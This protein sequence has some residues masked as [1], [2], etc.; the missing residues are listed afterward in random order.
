MDTN[1]KELIE[2]SC[3]SG[4]IT[5][6]KRNL[7]YKKAEELGISKEECDIYISG[8][9]NKINTAKDKPKNNRHILGYLLYF[10]AFW[11][12]FWSLHLFQRKITRP[13]GI[14]ILVLGVVIL[15]FSFK[16]MKKNS[17]V[18]KILSVIL[19]AGVLYLSTV[20]AF[21]LLLGIP[22][23]GWIALLFF[24]LFLITIFIFRRVFLMPQTAEKIEKMFT[25]KV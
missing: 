23:N 11:D 18:T 10:G 5:G 21:R 16:L 8:F 1:I 22:N 15:Y 6:A 24:I 25:K 12:I 7:I 17:L 19:L 9:L 2:L 13:Y 20:V 14:F 4:E 3:V